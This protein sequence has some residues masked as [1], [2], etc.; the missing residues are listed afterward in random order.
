MVK[1]T[2][3]FIDV[4]RAI[5]TISV[6]ISHIVFMYYN[7]AAQSVFTYLLQPS[8][9]ISGGGIERITEFLQG[10]S[11]G[12]FGVALFYLVSGFC[13]CF[14]VEKRS[15]IKFWLHRLVR[16]YPVYCIGFGMVFIGILLYANYYSR[17]GVQYSFN[18]YIV[19]ISL[20]RDWLW[21]PSIDGLSWT[22]ETQ[23]KIYF[24]ISLI[25]ASGTLDNYKGISITG[26]ICGVLALFFGVCA[27]KSF[28]SDLYPY[29]AFYTFSFGLVFCAFSMIGVCFYNYYLQRWSDEE[30]AKSLL[31]CII[32]ISIAVLGGVLREQALS[33]FYGYGAAGV[34][35]SVLF[36]MN[37]Q[38][39][40]K[41]VNIIS[42]YSFSLYVVQGG[43]YM[44]MSIIDH[45]IGVCIYVNIIITFVV[46]FILA[47][48]LYNVV[49][50]NTARIKI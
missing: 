27:R 2:T 5:A 4:I 30:F 41:I 20:I 22:L 25:R 16:I 15:F 24:V 45:S 32:G 36:V 1:R 12:S 11:F 37:P 8:E 13:I 26:I 35:F 29:A 31:W 50:K 21:K 28:G 48:F 9:N 6:I 38:K 19:Q 34:L 46:L 49:E 17:L 44:I 33:I 47:Y 14:S 42:K 10:F 39:E 7:G 3:Y 40:N 18:D 43:C 23:L